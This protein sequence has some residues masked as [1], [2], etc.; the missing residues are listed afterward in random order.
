MAP[1][2]GLL[3]LDVCQ[4]WRPIKSNQKNW[5]DVRF[6]DFLFHIETELGT[7][8]VYKCPSKSPNYYRRPLSSD[9]YIPSEIVCGNENFII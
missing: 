5:A 8:E 1:F 6:N 9:F 2:S 3:W 4:N 7:E